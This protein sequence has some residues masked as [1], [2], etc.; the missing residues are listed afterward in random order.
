MRIS[1]TA[2]LL[3]GLVVAGFVAG[4]RADVPASPAPPTPI[5]AIT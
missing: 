4:A 2:M 3:M 1:L 5:S